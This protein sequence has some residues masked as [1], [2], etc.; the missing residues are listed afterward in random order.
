MS[1]DTLVMSIGKR[2]MEEKEGRGVAHPSKKMGKTH[3]GEN[4]K[5]KGKVRAC[6]RF[7]VSELPLGMGN[8]VSTSKKTL[9]VE[10]LM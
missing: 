9:L 7:Q 4:I 1:K 2:T 3:E 6:R 8:Q 10:R 5:A